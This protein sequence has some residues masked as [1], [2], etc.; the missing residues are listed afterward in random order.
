MKQIGIFL[1]ILLLFINCDLKKKQNLKSKLIEASWQSLFNGKDLD[2]W[3]VKINGHKLNDNF[4]NTF[5]VENG[6]AKDECFDSHR[7]LCIDC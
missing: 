3:I 4:K 6:I 5:R 1:I 2:N 7:F